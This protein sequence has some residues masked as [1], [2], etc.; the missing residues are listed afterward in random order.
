M[1]KIQILEWPI[2]IATIKR[3][4]DQT[5]TNLVGTIL[6]QLIQERPSIAEPVA[7]LFDRLTERR[8]RPS[9][10]E[11]QTTLRLMVSSYSKVYVVVDALDECL[12][13]N[14][15]RS[16]LLATLRDLQ[17]WGIST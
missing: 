17:S 14:G 9:L 13:H 7:F 10:E 11:I 12:E 2:F 5:T 15:S 3:K 8:T 6:I 16:Q 4:A 1:C